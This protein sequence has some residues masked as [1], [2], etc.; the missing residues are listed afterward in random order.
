MLVNAKVRLNLDCTTGYRHP[1][2][3][4]CRIVFASTMA[5]CERLLPQRRRLPLVG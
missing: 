3:M 2:G 1:K 5:S 4:V